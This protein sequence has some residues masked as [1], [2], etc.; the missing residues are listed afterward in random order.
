[1]G[2]LWGALG[3]VA[4]Y[5]VGISREGDSAPSKWYE[6][7]AQRLGSEFGL[8]DMQQQKLRSLLVAYDFEERAIR[9]DYV[10]QMEVRDERLVG[11][12]RTLANK[13]LTEVFTQAQRDRYLSRVSAQEWSSG[14]AGQQPESGKAKPENH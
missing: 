12:S 10:M 13:L 3:F 7:Y 2:L 11:L 6:L 5:W 14:G 4:G 9:G 8:D 1:M